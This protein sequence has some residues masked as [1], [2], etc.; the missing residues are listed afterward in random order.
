MNLKNLTDKELVLKSKKN[1]SFNQ[2]Y[3]VLYSRHKNKIH[4]FLYPYVINKE[5][6]EDIVQD[7][8]IKIFLNLNQYDPHRVN[9]KTWMFTIVKNTA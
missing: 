8:L 7:S 5:D 2:I 4:N 6:K 9:F 3:S 1:G